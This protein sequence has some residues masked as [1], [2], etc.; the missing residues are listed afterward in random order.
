MKGRSDN[1]LLYDIL[2]C[3]QR[4]ASYIDDVGK[5]QFEQN[6]LLQDGLVRKLEI[7][8]EMRILTCLGEK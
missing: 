3:C 7:I 2:E 6:F 1:I 5:E 4:I 8:G